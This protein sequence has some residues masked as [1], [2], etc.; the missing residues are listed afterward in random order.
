M[1]SAQASSEKFVNRAG[2]ASSD[3]VDGVRSTSKDQNALAIA[4]AERHKQATTEALARGS[5]VKG[6]QKAGNSAWKNGVEKKGQ[7]RYADGVSNSA[8]KYAT[9]SGQY[10]SARSA[11][12]N[13]PRGVKGSE[14]NFQRSKAVGMALRALKV[15][16]SK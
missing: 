7:T 13:L 2:A 14:A 6:L 1:K 4:A 15:G 8:I 3:Y 10:D 5:Y 11:A 9:N 12:E 16:S